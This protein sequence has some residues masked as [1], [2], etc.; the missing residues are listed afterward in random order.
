MVENRGEIAA[1]EL[2]RG[3][4]RVDEQTDDN[5]RRHRV[6]RHAACFVQVQKYSAILESW[7]SAAL[8]DG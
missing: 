4:K 2:L 5:D 6:T 1:D 3:D 8:H 7:T